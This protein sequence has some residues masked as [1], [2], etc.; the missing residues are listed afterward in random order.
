MTLSETTQHHNT[1]IPMID[2]LNASVADAPRATDVRYA[3]LDGDVA[4]ILPIRWDDLRPSLGVISVQ[5]RFDRPV[6]AVHG[7][8]VSR[9]HLKRVTVAQIV[10]ENGVSHH[11]AWRMQETLGEDLLNAVTLLSSRECDHAPVL[12]LAAGALNNLTSGQATLA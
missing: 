6:G 12:V 2:A 5:A 8:T 10:D 4:H 11:E 1:T 7:M 9:N 3:T